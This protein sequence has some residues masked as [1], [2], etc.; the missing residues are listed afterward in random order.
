MNRITTS[1]VSVITF[2]TI[3]LAAH[4]AYSGINAPGLA[5]KASFPGDAACL[6]PNTGYADIRNNCSYAVEV[7]GTLPVLSEGWHDTSITLFG[8]S[9]WCQSVSINTVGNGAQ[10]GAPTWTTAGPPTWQTLA[11]GS[12]YVWA[13]AALDFRC[14]I[15]PGG[16]VGEFASN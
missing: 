5:L 15:E 10:V 4:D 14:V 7:S 12:R 6:S 9:S 13:W 8:S 1:L 3:G 16:V 11:L 2:A